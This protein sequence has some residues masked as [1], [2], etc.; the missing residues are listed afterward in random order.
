MSKNEPA[1]CT[2]NGKV[3]WYENV[4]CTTRKIEMNEWEQVH[5]LG[6]R[7]DDENDQVVDKLGVLEADEMMT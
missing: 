6:H 4:V 5:A 7:K 2:G 3:E 1:C